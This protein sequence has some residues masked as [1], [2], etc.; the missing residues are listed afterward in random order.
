MTVHKLHSFIL[1]DDRQASLLFKCKED[2]HIKFIKIWKKLLRIIYLV[3]LL[4]L[5]N[6]RFLA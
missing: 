6:L 3:G 2:N 5:I 1:T 4:E